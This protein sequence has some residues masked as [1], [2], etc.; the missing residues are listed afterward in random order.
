MIELA[1]D[2][3]VTGGNSSPAVD[4]FTVGTWAWLEGGEHAEASP[5]SGVP[6]RVVERFRAWGTDA[7]DVWVPGWGRA[8]RV[9]AARLRPLSDAAG[10]SV[11]AVL[12]AAAAARISDAVARDALV[13]PLEGTIEPL[14]HQISALA[15][16]V[17][18]DRV[19]WL[20]ADEVGLG[21]TIEA[22]LIFKELKARGLV[23]RVLVVAPTGLVRQWAEE[24]RRHFHEPF[25]IMVPGEF[26]AVRDALGLGVADNLWRVHDQVICPVD[27]VKPLEA[28][29]GWSREQL[30]RHN[31]ERFED[32]ITA[33]WDLVIVDEAHR[34]GGSTSQVARYKLG[35]ALAQASPYLLLLSATPHQG[36]TDAFRRLLA[37]LDPDVF[38]EDG[39]VS[40]DRVAPFVIRTEKRHAVGADG[41]PLFQPRT[42]ELRPVTWN[43]EDSAQRDLYE[44]VTHYVRQGYARAQRTRQTAVGFL[45]VLFQRMVTSSTRAVRV[46]LERRLAALAAAEE[47]ARSTP[48]LFDGGTADEDGFWEL[49]GDAQ[50]E[51]V[52][53]ARADGAGQERH[54]V[55]LLLDAARRCEA[56]GPD[57]KAQALLDAIVAL[58]GERADP[59]LK[60]LVFTEFL[61]TQAML[62]EFLEGRGIATVQ[63]NG[64][65]G[66]DERQRALANFAG[67]AR[68][69][70]STDAGGEGLNLQFASVVINYD[71]PWNPMKLE[72][73]IGRV[74]RI[75][76]KHPVHALNFA[77][78]ESVELR[79]QEV[80]EE[81]LRRILDDLGIDKLADVLDSEAAG[82]EF[83][84]L[85]ADVSTAP[86]QLEARVAAFATELRDRAAAARA[87]LLILGDSEPPDAAAARELAEHRLPR[88]TEQLVVSSLRLDEPRGSLVERVGPGPGTWRLRWAD[89]VETGRAVFEA[90]Y[91]TDPTVEHLT[92]DDERVRAL[93]SH[94]PV[95]APGQPIPSVV[96]AGISE[97]VAGTWGLWRVSIEGAGPRALRILP[98]FVADDGRVLAPTARAVW[99][100]LLEAEPDALDLGRKAVAGPDAAQVFSR[101]ERAVE[102]AGAGVYEGLL[103]EQR[104][105]TEREARKMADAFT[106][107]RRAVGRVGL[108]EVR[109]YRMRQL[110]QDVRAWEALVRDRETRVAPELRALVVVRVR[111]ADEQAAPSDTAGAEAS[112]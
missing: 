43:T 31:R 58:E 41:R 10:S 13:A 70:V 22:G 86:D 60:V 99:D 65:M 36:K 51:A 18:S 76:Q 83:E 32:L 96:V 112:A 3:M 47:A 9:A 93:A 66:P 74:D 54:E 4:G 17:G 16:A 105:A 20:L 97:R 104:A 45:M 7:Y 5:A 33:G 26:S 91:A 39:V 102:E 109:E 59:A 94:L 88:W 107:R 49:D 87:G 27:A 6:C 61:P 56:A 42:V 82:A 100:R 28:R 12:A 2:D 79:V 92:L 15:R 71:L 37:F 48:S 81:K 21:K 38:V 52:V 50:F 67:D 63:L 98:V 69:L 111:A 84:S 89:G 103:A 80:L 101:L 23:K 14:P 1:A 78:A 57:A 55:E 19:R 44:S 46:A 8:L 40:R 64:A 35:D 77:L 11:H 108:R 90:R 73:R 25:R 75:G 29:R 68:V 85:Y 110:E 72:Q 24:L 34:L 53:Q 95:W 30:A 62:A 106:A